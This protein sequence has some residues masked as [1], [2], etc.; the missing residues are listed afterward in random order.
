MSKL[1]HLNLSLLLTVCCLTFTLKASSI[2]EQQLKI[3]PWMENNSN[4]DSVTLRGNIKEDV[5]QAKPLTGIGVIGIRFIHQTGYSSYIDQVYP[6]SPAYREGLKSRDLIFAVDGVRT[7]QLNSDGVYQ[8]LAGDP[9]TRVK[10]FITRGQSMFN[11]ELIR[12][13]L[14]NLFPEV[15]NRYLS[16]PIAIPV[17]PRDFIPYH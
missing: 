8:L 5:S 6:N 17:N 3:P 16:G 11:L 12:E 7:D 2:E 9:G 10:I 15:Q 4:S 14:A 13:D 1:L